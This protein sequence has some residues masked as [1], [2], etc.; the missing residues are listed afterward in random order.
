ML[1]GIRV[2]QPGSAINGELFMMRGLIG[3]TYAKILVNGIPVKPYMTNGMPI[4]AQLPIQQADRIEVIYGP[5]AALYGADAATGIINIVIENSDR[6][7]F[8]NASLHL[9]TQDYSSLNV[10][11]GGKLGKGR[12]VLKFNI[13]GSNTRMVDQRIIHDDPYLFNITT[14]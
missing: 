9:G 11:V 7:I 10:S 2:S 14:F 6:P 4:G 3:N 13:F 5:A 8:T 1:P 12:K